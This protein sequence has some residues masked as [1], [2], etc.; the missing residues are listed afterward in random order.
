MLHNDLA[1][2]VMCFVLFITVW[3]CVFLL[4]FNSPIAVFVHF[5]G[6]KLLDWKAAK[7]VKYQSWVPLQKPSVLIGRP[8]VKFM[9]SH[10]IVTV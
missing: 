5:S 7:L 4:N 1:I 6:D 10:S 8:K 2:I 3:K 9:T